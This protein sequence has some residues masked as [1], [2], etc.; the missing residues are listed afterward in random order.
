MAAVGGGI[1]SDYDLF[2]LGPHATGSSTPPPMEVP[3]GGSFTVY[4]IAKDS[5][6]AGIPC[7]MSGSS[8]EWTRVAFSIVQNAVG[9]KDTNTGHYTDMF[10]LQSLRFENIYQWQDDVVDG[11]NVLIGHDWS[12]E[13]CQITSGK[14]AVHF[15]H[16]A[17]T[18]G[19]AAYIK[20]GVLSV[21]DRPGV[22]AHWLDVWNNVCLPLVQ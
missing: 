13:D 22:I 15:S 21:S 4:S 16:S 3:N 18:N 14:R 5:Q 2:P 12:P 9:Q 19:D 11:E 20:G 1:M 17:M 10:A 8:S 6:G 7:L